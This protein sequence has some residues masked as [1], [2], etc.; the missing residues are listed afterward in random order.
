MVAPLGPMSLIVE[1]AVKVERLAVQPSNGILQFAANEAL[2]L[3]KSRGNDQ[4]IGVLLEPSQEKAAMQPDAIEEIS[5][6]VAE[7]EDQQLVP[8]PLARSK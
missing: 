3:G 2:V 8:H 7:I 5:L 1:C 6:E 4:R